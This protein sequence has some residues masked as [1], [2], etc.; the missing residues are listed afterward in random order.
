MSMMLLCPCLSINIGL[1]D[2]V[3]YWKSPSVLVVILVLVHCTFKNEVFGYFYI[4]YILTCDLISIFF[5]IVDT[6]I[7]V[8]LYIGHYA[9]YKLTW[10]DPHKM[11]MCVQ[12][13]L[14]Q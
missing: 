5:L 3:L 8:T 2:F 6:F 1:S 12:T 7:V 10:N 9:V 13:R 11:C 14:L 4:F